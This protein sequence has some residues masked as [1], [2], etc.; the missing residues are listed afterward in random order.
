MT[1]PWN[2]H[3]DQG[4]KT[5]RRG[6]RPR[7]EL[8][9]DRMLLATF[10][11]TDTSDSASDTGSLRYAI[12]QNNLNGP[13]PNTIDFK[14]AGTGVQTITPATALPAATVPVTIDGT[15]QPGYSGKP[16][17]VLDGTSA[18]SSTNG[19]DLSAANSKISGLA[20]DSFGGD[21]I[22]LAG[23]GD[24]LT[25]CF[26]GVDATGSVAAGNGGFY[27]IDCTAGGI[28]IGGTAAGAGNVI[29]GNSGNGIQ[30]QGSGTGDVVQG[31]YIGT[32]VTAT[33]ALANRGNG[34]LV[35]GPGGVLIGGTIP[36][37]RNIISGNGV[38]GVTI[39]TASDLIEGNFIGTD[40][41][42]TV[43]LPNEQGGVALANEGSGVATGNSTVG[44]TAAGA[45]NV[46][47]G[48]GSTG[49]AILTNSNVVEG[50][51]IGTDVT[52]TVAVPN[53]GNGISIGA[54]PGGVGS[55]NTIGGTVAAARNVISGNTGGATGVGGVFLG[56]AGSGN[57]IEGNYIGIDVTGTKA[58]ANLGAGVGLESGSDGDTVGGTISGAGNV[59]AGNTGDGVDLFI[60]DV[61][62]EGN[63]I[64]TDATGTEALPNGG[65][66]VYGGNVVDDTIGGATAAARNIISGN[67]QYGVAI[68]GG[69]ATKYLVE[70]NY[71]GTDVTGTVGLG[72]GQSGV[73][74]SAQSNTIGGT[75]PG[76]G[77]LISANGT[78]HDSGAPE[79]SD[80]GIA[81]AG[82]TFG[83]TQN[84]VQGN[85]IGTDVTG[86][87]NLGNFGDGVDITEGSNSNTIGGS[88]T[89][90]PNVI[91]FNGNEGV[92]V[93]EN[94][95]M[96]A[97]SRNSI[98][99]NTNLGINLH[100]ATGLAGGNNLEPAPVLTSYTK[101]AS[102]SIQTGWTLSAAASTSFTIEFFASALGSSS[103]V[104]EGQ[105]FLTSVPVTTDSSGNASFSESLTLPAG[106]TFITATATDPNGNTS[107]FSL[108]AT[109][110]A[111]TSSLNPSTLGTSVTFT[112][113]VT[114]P[115][116]GT[117]TGTVTFTI[118]G[119]A[120]TPS[121]LAVVN[122]VDQA[123]FSTRT[124]TVG[125]HTITAAYSGDT[126]FAPSTSAPLTQTVN[127]AP[128]AT[129]TSLSAATNPS[130]FGENAT[131]TAVVAP[132]AQTVSTPTG[133]V[134]FTIDGQSEPP[135]D[136]AVVNGADEAV[137]GT[138]TLTVG[139][140][141]I[142]A[143]YDGDSTFASS[144]A[145]PLTQTVNAPTTTMLRTSI[146]PS[147]LGQSV[148]FTATVAGPGGAG[149]PSGSVS[150]EEGS[151]ILESVMLNTSGQAT[152]TTSTLALGSDAITAVY[153]GSGNFLA[154]S[155]APVMQ[156]VN[157]LPV[158]ATT[159]HVASSID[160]ATIGEAVTFAAIVAPASGPGTPTG[161]VTF[162]I[163][164]QA[165]MPVDL[166]IVGGQD[167]A[168]LPPITNLS[169]GPHTIAATY[170]GD[171]S[172]ADS[173]AT[174]LT[175]TVNAP[176]SGGTPSLDASATRLESSADPSTAGQAVIFTATVAPASGP[177][178]P[179][180][181][182]TFTIDGKAGSPVLLTDV[183]GQDQATLTLP[184]LAAGSYTISASYSG[185]TKFAPSASS[186]VTQVVDASAP[187]SPPITPVTEDGPTIVSVL[188]YGYH[189]MPTTL[190]LT[191]DQALD[192]ATAEDANDY[193]V[194]S[195][196]GG[197]IGMKSAVYDP[198]ALTVTLHPT[199]RIDI[200][201]TYTLIV[202][203]TAPGGLTNSRGQLL[204]GADDGQTGSDYRGPLTWRNL[205]L[206]PPAPKI[207]HQNKSVTVKLK[208]RSAAA[209]TLSHT[210]AP[211][212]RSVGFR[213]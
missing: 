13:G 150:L 173:A 23:S 159:T 203:G 68:P 181:T 195:P 109:T 34:I 47:S 151:T 137:F 22:V 199:Q 74:I 97:I 179:T 108:Q 71:I 190:V 186:A 139:P 43:A 209:K 197:Q 14:I 86:T 164:G 1:K 196:A 85:L 57:A 178:A 204:D 141:T 52:G 94:S 49:I 205:V 115:A 152:F 140:H 147:A 193:R 213:R 126:A 6:R 130:T 127:P 169:V 162:S 21:G 40:V 187:I 98:F 124:L 26:V 59:I 117:P 106:E 99:G 146:N 65:D 33:K 120:E 112:A 20:V 188:R 211:F 100:S 125:P 50:N 133:T 61:L 51:L 200:H 56:L 104:S 73:F 27:A 39:Y 64:G 105:T 87:A 37:A 10:T 192:A 183:N 107:Q 142:S 24:V 78:A 63:L 163:D 83:A 42:G 198:A 30:F 138:A 208:T 54:E 17:I 118:D 81:I 110:T 66:G 38:T 92:H 149:T 170:S 153:A 93:D 19:L 101:L 36:G 35:Q 206:D 58:L 31:N 41:T 15:T 122:G 156:A 7:L 212:T 207:S 119:H 60:D 202:D 76:S 114:N 84:V 148:T 189:W 67:A 160:P 171:S 77:N 2:A 194:I 44:G 128:L 161:T 167:E 89:N 184:S 5:N 116:T 45:G 32:D 11:V 158:Q 62:V 145:P 79:Q 174:P 18:G 25:G 48:N 113:V 191:F 53:D 144:A 88:A 95:T 3:R 180:G 9:E 82:G 46:I 28:T 111:L 154:S 168:F 91:A 143:A 155:S 102:G 131:F 90:A 55:D 176:A 172:F 182:V 185:D 96:D 69:D 135:V 121:A 72:N 12:T 16:L 157:P 29:S 134:T 166:Q 165:Q 132:T 103:G 123:T 4:P 129:T 136:L 210:V 75:A 175:Q 201:Y 80:D 8:L 177:G 70:G